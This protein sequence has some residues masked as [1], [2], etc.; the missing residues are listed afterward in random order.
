MGEDT[1]ARSAEE[2]RGLP[3]KIGFPDKWIDYS[4]VDIDP[5]DLLGNV[6]RAHNADVDRHLDEV[7]KP[8]DPTSGS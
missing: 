8:V 7:G 2:A 4:A 1:K 6:E 3:A 5:T